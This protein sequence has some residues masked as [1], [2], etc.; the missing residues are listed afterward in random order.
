MNEKELLNEI[1]E[2][3]QKLYQNREHEGIEAVAKLLGVFQSLIS[4]QTPEQSALGGNF[5]LVM[6]RELLDAYQNAD[7]LQMAD[8]LTEKAVLFVQFYYQSMEIK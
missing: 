8:C 3:S 7:M 1:E 5:A 4:S 6:L 2:I